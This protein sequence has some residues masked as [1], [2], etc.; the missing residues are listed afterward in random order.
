[1]IAL[2]GTRDLAYAKR[3]GRRYAG[4]IMAAVADVAVHDLFPLGTGSEQ[5]EVRVRSDWPPLVSEAA[6]PQIRAA[7]EAGRV[8]A[9]VCVLAV[10]D[11]ALVGVP[12]EYFT[13]AARSIREHAPFDIT[14]VMA[15]TNGKL[16]Y[17]ADSEAFFDGSMIYGAYP[18]RPAMCAPGTDRRLAEAALRALRA[19]KAAQSGSETDK[20]REWRS[21]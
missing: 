12:A 17:V 20:K 7:A 6:N 19:A 5:V 4:Y 3:L 21:Y 11:L 13:T 9:E 2:G 14:S 15:L 1:M 18:Q 8:P 10:G 16:M